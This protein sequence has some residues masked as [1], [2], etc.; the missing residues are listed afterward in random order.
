MLIYGRRFYLIMGDFD[1]L[2]GFIEEPRDKKLR[3]IGRFRATSFECNISAG[4]DS[5]KEAARKLAHLLEG[6]IAEAI[7]R[8]INPYHTRVKNL[9]EFGKYCVKNR[10]L[11][12]KVC[13]I[14]IEGGLTL[15]CYD[16]T[17]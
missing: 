17:S 14:E 8:E 13:D 16:M 2:I 10:R 7:D 1:Y 3:E 4:G 12:K 11:P 5:K 15:R 6:Y 9:E